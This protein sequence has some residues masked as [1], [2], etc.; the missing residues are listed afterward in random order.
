MRFYKIPTQTGYPSLQSDLEGSSLFDV[1]FE[2]ILPNFQEETDAASNWY[3]SSQ[4]PPV[5]EPPLWKPGCAD[6]LVYND[7]GALATNQ[8]ATM[9]FP[10]A[11]TLTQGDPDLV[12]GVVDIEFDVN[13]PEYQD[14]IVN[15]SSV[16]SVSSGRGHGTGVAGAVAASLNNGYCVAGGAPNVKLDFRRPL[17]NGILGSLWQLYRL[18][19]PVITLS[20]YSRDWERN[21]E[22]IVRSCMEEITGGGTVITFAVRG[23]NSL[24]FDNIPGF[25]NVGMA[26][27]NGWFRQYPDKPSGVYDLN[28][29]IYAASACNIRLLPGGCGTKQ[30][31]SSIAAPYVAGAVALMLSVNPCLSPAEVEEILIETSHEISPANLPETHG[32]LRGKGHLNAYEAVRAAMDYT[33]ATASKRLTVSA[34]QRMELRG[35]GHVYDHIK[36]ESGGR[37]DITDARVLMRGPNIGGRGRG[38]IVVERGAKLVVTNSTIMDSRSSPKCTKYASGWDGIRV[39][40]NV[41]REQPDLI[42][43]DGNLDVD[44]PIGGDDAGVVIL[45]PG[46]KITNAHY[47]VAAEAPGIPYSEQRERFGGLV[48]AIGVEFIDNQRAAHFQQYPS[49]SSGNDFTDKSIFNFCTIRYTPGDPS[50]QRAKGITSWASKGITVTNCNFNT[51]QGESLATVDGGF[52]VLGGNQFSYVDEFTTDNRG[53]R[54]IYALASYPY[55]GELR[56]GSTQE[57]LPPNYFYTKHPRDRFIT[58]SGTSGVRGAVVS[59]NTFVNA[60][61][62]SRFVPTAID[63]RGASRLTV[64]NNEMR[65]LRSLKAMNTGIHEL[66]SGNSVACNDVVDAEAGMSFSGDNF[67]LTFRN[68]VFSGRGVDKNIY[69]GGRVDPFQ[70]SPEQPANNNFST[71]NTT[72]DIVVNSPDNS[73]TYYYSSDNTGSNSFEPRG[74]V[75]NFLLRRSQDVPNFNCEAEVGNIAYSKSSILALYGEYQHAQQDLSD[76]GL[77]RANH[78]YRRLDISLSTYINNRKHSSSIEDIEDILNEINSVQA[79]IRLYSIY[80]ERSDFSSANQMLDKLYSNP[81]LHDFVLVQRINISRKK[82]TSLEANLT[83][84]DSIFLSRVAV[85]DGFAKPYARA[86]LYEMKDVTFYEDIFEEK[87]KT[88][89]EHS[90]GNEIHSYVVYPNPVTEDVIRI[91]NIE[92]SAIIQMVTIE[93]ALLYS[94]TQTID[95]VHEIPRPINSGIYILL[96]KTKNDLYTRKIVVQ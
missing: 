2:E 64:S 10:C 29:D 35:K 14:R 72:S 96:I 84:V 73:F 62:T 45:Q 81:E 47:A 13:H 37:L 51:V 86:L 19:H 82:V 15:P 38:Q 76:E 59:N 48:I 78:I 20:T 42:D 33:P 63:V 49:P 50:F 27:N 17:F 89:D 85:K 92:E 66:V 31:L 79:Q 12:V 46:T 16:P 58:V 32:Q 34:G 93:G 4:P 75:S 3:P 41:D 60:G 30:G 52:M 70:G 22:T 87:G 90:A 57:D 77:Y 80:F 91:T 25:I 44:A 94:S 43:A 56:V 68:N 61:S 18:G 69:V 40:G 83:K 53:H 88:Y 28:L 21:D 9:G 71:T 1:V 11:W 55:S 7:P 95:K 5:G 23:R 24:H 26:F 39:H 8:I 67:G 74:I 6:P 54:H 36:I 65:K